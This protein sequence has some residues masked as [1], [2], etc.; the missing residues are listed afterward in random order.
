MLAYLNFI[1]HIFNNFILAYFFLINSFYL[2]FLIFSLFGIFRYRSLTSNVR[3]NEVLS[4]PLAKPVSIIAPA[5]NEELNIIESVKSLLSLQYPLHEVIVVN[6]GSNDL[7]L[8]KLIRTFDLKKVKKVFKKSI[9]TQPIR[10]IY[11]SPLEPKLVVVDKIN[12]KKADALNAGLNVSRY[13]LFCAI[14]TDS[15]LDRDAL[16][17]VARPFHEDPERTVG[18][19][20]I[21]SL[22]NG[23]VIERGRILRVRLPRNFFVRFQIIEYLR[24]FLGGRM[25]LSMLKSILVISGT[26]GI[27]R[28]DIALQIGGYRND[29]IGEDMDLVVRMR[30]Y[31]HEQK[32][33]YRI[34]FIPDPICWTEAPETLKGLER[35]RNRW[36]RGL[37][38]S[39]FH[40]FKM[41]L[42]PRYGATGM[43]AMPFYV[44]F[45]MFG[46]LLELL[47]YVIFACYVFLG[48]VN[49]PFA[50]D[51][52]LLAIVFGTLISLAAILLE[53]FFLRRYPRLT[54]ILIIIAFGVLENFLYRQFLSFVRAKAFFDLTRGEKK[55]GQMERKGFVIEQS[56][57]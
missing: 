2:F 18:A 44:I 8:E 7:T 3:M 30:K 32:R 45:E 53:E 36:H 40:S 50:L 14:D 5:F 21:V 9:E 42:N 35:Q 48:K 51:F 56:H 1:I 34:T 55:W 4:L 39:L 37:I 54:D 33:P 12:G 47:G 26:F 29:T 23:C 27:F 28:K 11:V 41:F 38:E 17:K 13:P 20:G 49:Y 24:A 10:G 46:P 43:F 52:F 16:L 6:D 31:L 19:G 15:V 57:S 22:S 25:A